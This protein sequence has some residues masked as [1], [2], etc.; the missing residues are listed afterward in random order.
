LLPASLDKPLL[1]IE[2]DGMGVAA[3]E[4][5]EDNSS[6]TNKA[7]ADGIIAL[8]EQW[9]AHDPFRNW[10]LTQ[11]RHPIGIG[12]ICMYAAQRNLIERRLRQSP[13]G[14][15]LE[16]HVKVGTVDSYQGKENPIVVLS[17][18]RNNDFGLVEGGIKRIQEG[19]LSAP[20]RINVAASRAMDRLVIVGARKRW[21]SEGPVG[22]LAEGFGRQI[23]ADSASVV[24]IE[25][26]LNRDKR[27]ANDQG[28]AVPQNAAL[29]SG[30]VHGNV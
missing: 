30:G 3:H 13:L 19:F 17:L 11:D 22:R 2:T 20:N 28:P 24:E 26:L 18:V 8:L 14:Y 12:I 9:H 1:W 5:K 7:E 10:L 23:K 25:T 6:R 15:L 4:R 29:A 21:R 16:R 27:T